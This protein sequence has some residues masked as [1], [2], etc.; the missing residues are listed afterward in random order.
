MN[1]VEK[2]SRY[3]SS[4]SGALEGAANAAIKEIPACGHVF[5]FKRVEEEEVMRLL[6]ALDVNKAVRVDAIGAKLL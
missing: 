2:L 1:I 5:S 4:L 3:F 6:G